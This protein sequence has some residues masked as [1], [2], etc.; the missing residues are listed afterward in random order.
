MSYNISSFK[1]KELKDLKIPLKAFINSDRPDWMPSIEIPR[2]TYTGKIILNCGCGQ[3]IAGTV[4]EG[5]L[6]VETIDLSGEGSGSFMHYVGKDALKQ[7]TGTLKAV[8]VWEN[9]DMITSL[10]VVDGHVKETEIY[11]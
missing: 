6:S 5:I 7:S 11:L 1:L 8:L 10:E 3:T 2:I 9:G 4:N